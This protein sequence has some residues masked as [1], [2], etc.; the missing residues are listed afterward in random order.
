MYIDY[1]PNSLL[2]DIISNRC[3][4]FIGAGFSKNANSNKP[5]PDWNELGKKVAGYFSDYQYDNAVETLSH[6]ENEYSRANLIEILAK[7]LNINVISPGG[8]HLSFCKLYFDLICTTNFDFLLETAFSELYAKKGKP[9]HV[10][11][12]EDRLSTY[13]NE[14]TTIVKMHGDFNEPAKM[15]VTENDY[16]T[17]ISNNPLLCT[18]IANLLITRTPLLIGYSLNDPDIRMIWNIISS[19]LNSLRR[20]GYVLAVSASENDITRFKRRGMKVINLPG[21]KSDYSKIYTTLFNELLVYWNEKNSENMKTSNE[22]AIGILKYSSNNTGQMCFF[23]VPYERL[24][25][26]KKYIFPIVEG[27]GMVPVSADEYVLPGDNISA[28]INTLIQ[29][30]SIAVI[31]TTMIS[32]NISMEYGIINEAKIP[33]LVISSEQFVTS[34][35]DIS[36]N[37]LLFGDFDKKLEHLINGVED[38]L[39][40]YSLSQNSTDYLFNEPK[41]LF[42]LKEYNAAI[43]S[44]IRLLEVELKEIISKVGNIAMGATTSLNQLIKI[45]GDQTGCDTTKMMD[46]VSMRNV[47]VHSANFTVTRKLA[48]EVVEGIYETVKALPDLNFG[49]NCLVSEQRSGR[50]NR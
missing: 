12:N 47:V 4:P 15:V 44:A 11:A 45:L 36:I 1:L 33:H 46:W 17:F 43:I 42:D 38:F 40:E 8:C 29:K 22:D 48:K 30:S 35:I 10:I 21:K 7:E 28:K 5:I 24:S 6:Y 19:R 26:Y 27:L 3:I 37:R 16:D 23:S 50:I 18:Y 13:F 9:Y 25:L 32:S 2:E 34:G 39:S 14:K 20:T 41:R 49:E 31:D